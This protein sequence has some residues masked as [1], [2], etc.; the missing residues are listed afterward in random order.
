MLIFL[1]LFQ[2]VLSIQGDD[3]PPC[4][5]GGVV[6]NIP[7]NTSVVTWYPYNF[8]K[9][10]PTFPQNYECLYKINV[11]SGWFAQI[12]LA[13][14]NGNNTSVVVQVIDQLQRIENVTTSNYEY[15]YFIANGGTIKLST[16]NNRVQFGFSVTW[17]QYNVKT[18]TAYNISKSS[19]DPLVFRGYDL[20]PSIMKADTKVSVTMMTP[21]YYLQKNLRGI[22]FFDGPNWNSTSLGTGL[23]LLNSK[24]QYVSSGQYMTILFLGRTFS[25][26]N[27]RMLI[28]DYEH[29]KGIMQFQGMSCQ[30][31][32]ECPSIVLDA[33]SG[34]SALQSYTDN[35]IAYDE[36]MSLEG[37]GTLEVYLGSVTENKTNMV[38]SYQA[39]NNNAMRFPQEVPG[40][41]K[42]Y[43]LR[44]GNATITIL[45]SRY[46]FAETKEFGRK[47]FIVSPNYGSLSMMQSINGYI[48]SPKN[49]IANFRFSVNA[50]MDGGAIIKI[51]GRK[52]HQDVFTRFYNSSNP[53]MFL[54]ECFGS[55][56]YVEYD[57]GSKPT[58]GFYMEFHIQQGSF[59]SSVLTII[60][61]VLLFNLFK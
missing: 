26:D 1:F 50:D 48:E 19:F 16:E 30:D 18:Q 59:K 43:V 24:T 45:P 8:T 55:D 60:C 28:Q 9:T 21:I 31:N 32:W 23:Q 22:I 39:Q 61:S 4:P 14:F 6:F 36:I 49:S 25:Y 13:V 54:D 17:N 53:P 35:S 58:T 12:D 20:Y 37:T 52:N 3:I 41:V 51:T 27:I 38:A 7:Q 2:L 42:T 11:P 5:N 29:T 57:T 44:E 40:K 46:N 15:F 47:G 33:S 10:V 56:L 34:P